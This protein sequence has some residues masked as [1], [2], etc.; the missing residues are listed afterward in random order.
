M[1]R[2]PVVASVKILP[3][4]DCGEG[5]LDVSNEHMVAPQVPLQMWTV[6]RDA[7]LSWITQVDDDQDAA[8]VHSIIQLSELGRPR[9][10]GSRFHAPAAEST[11]SS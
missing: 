9:D 10:R 6:K 8:F 4:T 3:N 11:S 2:S 7:Y 1:A 5:T